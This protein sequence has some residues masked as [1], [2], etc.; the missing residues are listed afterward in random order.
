MHVNLLSLTISRV[1]SQRR[2]GIPS[3][4]SCGGPMSLTDALNA[5][6]DKLRL[7]SYACQQSPPHKQHVPKEGPISDARIN[8]DS[9][10]LCISFRCGLAVTSILR[11]ASTGA[12][13][14]SLVLIHSSNA[15]CSLS[16]GSVGLLLFRRGL[17][18][19]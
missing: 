15:D 10:L 13:P 19:R 18:E 4:L 2:T 9:L 14:T 17:C 1:V 8:E 3:G 5:P 11:A 6:R 16:I 7:V 12:L